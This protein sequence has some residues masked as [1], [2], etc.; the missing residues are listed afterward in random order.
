M[1]NLIGDVLLLYDLLAHPLRSA[2]LESGINT[3][4]QQLTWL[5]NHF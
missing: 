1:F 2:G 5:V 3:Q 4:Q